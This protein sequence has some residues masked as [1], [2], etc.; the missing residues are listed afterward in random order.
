MATRQTTLDF[1]TRKSRRLR[2]D[3][4]QFALPPT[5]LVG[6]PH[7]FD[8]LAADGST[9]TNFNLPANGVLALSHSV[10]VSAGNITINVG[11]RRTFESGDLESDEV[12][13]GI[14]GE[15]GQ[16]VSITRDGASIAGTFT[17]YLVDSFGK[18]T[19]I[20]TCTFS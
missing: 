12:Q 16:K 11:D 13:Q 18:N 7:A 2:A 4:N 8:G 17:L 6:T 14:W 9:S 5:D 10:A 19:A 1:Y 15:E 3:E 20:A